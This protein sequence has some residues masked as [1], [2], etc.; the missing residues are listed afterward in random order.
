MS[1]GGSDALEVK[2]GESRKQLEWEQQRAGDW[3]W[4]KNRKRKFRDRDQSR[5]NTRKGTG[6]TTKSSRPMKRNVI[7][8]KS[9]GNQGGRRK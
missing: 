6:K 9:K 5:R 4:K 1:G 7:N 3:K 8:K 2:V